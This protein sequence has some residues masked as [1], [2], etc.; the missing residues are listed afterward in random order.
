MGAS[1]LPALEL[2]VSS[3]LSRVRETPDVKASEIK[4]FLFS[5]SSFFGRVTFDMGS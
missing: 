1:L 2:A 3:D 5:F 4:F